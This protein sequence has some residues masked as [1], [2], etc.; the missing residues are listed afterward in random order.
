MLTWEKKI[1]EKVIYLKV[2]AQSIKEQ[3]VSKD[4]IEHTIQIRRDT[5]NRSLEDMKNRGFVEIIESPIGRRDR[6]LIEVTPKGFFW[7]FDKEL[8]STDAFLNGAKIL[9]LDLATGS[10]REIYRKVVE[11]LRLQINPERFEDVDASEIAYDILSITMCEAIKEAEVQNLEKG[12]AE[13]LLSQQFGKMDP[14]EFEKAKTLTVDLKAYLIDKR[15]EMNLRIKSLQRIIT[16]M[17][18]KKSI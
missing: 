10:Y 1:L 12:D 11:R 4:K 5:L 2:N 16:F 8:C 9:P 13:S 3:E 6:Y 15:N 17:S 14:S 18:K 7:A